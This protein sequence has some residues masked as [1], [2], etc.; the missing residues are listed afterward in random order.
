MV[1]GAGK[2]ERGKKMVEERMQERRL[3]GRKSV[4]EKIEKER[5]DLDGGFFW[6]WGKGKKMYVKRW[7]GSNGILG[8][9]RG[10]GGGGVR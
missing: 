8:L 5:K 7:K 1:R 9:R 6:V 3:R 10:A 2:D 4:N